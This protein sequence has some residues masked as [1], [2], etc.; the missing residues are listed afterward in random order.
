MMPEPSADLAAGRGA[1]PAVGCPAAAAPRVLPRLWPPAR[2]AGLLD[3]AD[4][5]AAS[6]A[7]GDPQLQPS[8]GSM[9]LGALG[10]KVFAGLLHELWRGPAADVLRDRVGAAPLC[11]VSQCWVRRQ[12]PA[13]L[14]PA[15]QFPHQWHQDGA[16]GC[17]FDGAPGGES[18][19]PIT[20]LWL[21]LLDC[22]DDAPSLEWVDAQLHAVLQPAELSDD[23]VL[24]RWGPQARRHARLAAGESLVFGP[25][26]LHRTH[27]TAAMRRR[28]VSVEWRFIAAGAVPQRLKDEAQCPVP[29]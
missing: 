11:L 17:R 5:I 8:S 6:L 9:R 23:A 13:A 16:L 1:D 3:L 27:V 14:R 7:P 2:C 20:T 29:T 22:G 21:P 28:R 18:L 15:G 12:Y 4:R 25:G 10:G 26:L 19:A 24:R